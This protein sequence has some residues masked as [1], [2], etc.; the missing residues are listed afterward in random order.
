MNEIGFLASLAIRCFAK[1]HSKPLIFG[2]IE[3]ND[4]NFLASWYIKYEALEFL[5]HGFW[6][7]GFLNTVYCFSEWKN[8]VS[9]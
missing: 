3:E 9:F 4:D 6:P 2:K 8:V 7:E 5:K 1:P